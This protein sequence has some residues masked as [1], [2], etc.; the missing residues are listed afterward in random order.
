MS[1]LLKQW[2]TGI[3]GGQPWSSYWNTLFTEDGLN[4]LLT[5]DGL[6]YLQYNE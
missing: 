2:A 5:E 3:A 1:I 6:N 4:F